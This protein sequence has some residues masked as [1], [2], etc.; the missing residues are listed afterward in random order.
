MN[1]TLAT[2]LPGL[3]MLALGGLL[4]WNGP[5]V[6][7][8]AKALPRSRRASWLF[9][10]AGALWFL[11]RLV[12]LSTA[13]ELLPKPLLIVA[14]GAVAVLSFNYAPDF[15]A[16]RGLAVLILLGA[17]ELLYAAYM[18]WAHPQRLFMV[19]AVYVAIVAA[20]YLGG[21]PYRLRDFF[22]WL[23]ARNS[24]ARVLGAVLGG[25]GALL[26]VLAFTY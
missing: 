21:Y 26:A 16:V 10:V 5:A 11:W 17:G 18:E 15:L 19:G 6:G 20:I 25:Y 12:H 8:T 9:M 23:F 2:L 3:L 14:F 4:L 22:G 1:L 13:D 24:R 7:A